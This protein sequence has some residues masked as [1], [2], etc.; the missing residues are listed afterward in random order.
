MA[1]KFQLVIW[2]FIVLSLSATALFALTPTSKLFDLITTVERQFSGLS[3]HTV[4]LDDVTIKYLRGGRGEPLIML[5]G[6]GADKDNWTRIAK[7]LSKHYDVIAL[8]I[9]GFGESTQ[10]LALDYDVFSQVARL[11]AFANALNIDKFHLAGSS[12]GGYIAGNF[13]AKHAKKVKALWLI[14]PFGVM[15]AEPSEMFVAVKNGANPA[16]LPRNESEFNDLFDFLFV[17]PPFIPSPIV[18]HLAQK[19]A[20]RVII[21]TKIFEQMHRMKDNRPYPDS[22]L[23]QALKD[24]TGNVLVTWGDKDRVLNVDGARVLSTIIPQANI[25]IMKDV[26]HLPMLEKPKSSAQTFIAFE[27][28]K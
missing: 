8:D 24:Y 21:N 19:S 18:T 1:S 27:Q 17:E 13:A 2:T 23:E 16:V 5:H 15:T 3:S 10:T 25:D 20:D 4:E 12:M 6:F 7:Y 28:G 9:P 22:P 11:D 26:G 14:S